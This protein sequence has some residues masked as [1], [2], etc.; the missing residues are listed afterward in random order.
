MALPC[1]KTC[2]YYCEGCHKT[3]Q[4]WKEEKEKRKKQGEKARAY[5]KY[6]RETC[7]AIL[8]QFAAIT[9]RRIP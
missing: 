4:S 3:C 2:L 6:H 8:R 7:T 5:L 1:S 9:Y